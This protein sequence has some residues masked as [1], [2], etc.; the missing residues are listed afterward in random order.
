[1]R[2][3][4]TRCMQALEEGV[5]TVIWRWEAMWAW[6]SWRASCAVR[7]GKRLKEGRGTGKRV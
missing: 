3:R 5:E 7:L 2:Q 4:G 1:M 6:R